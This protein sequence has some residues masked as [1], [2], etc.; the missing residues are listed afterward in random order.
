MAVASK[1]FAMISGLSG[2]LES[3]K[4]LSQKVVEGL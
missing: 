1:R 2:S 4:R 3:L